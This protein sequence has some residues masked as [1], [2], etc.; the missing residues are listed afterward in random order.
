MNVGV[1]YRL[2]GRQWSHLGIC[3]T[4]R[5]H[6]QDS[7]YESHVRPHILKDCKDSGKGGRVVEGCKAPVLHRGS[8]VRKA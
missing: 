5:S 3:T 4:R 2:Q 6:S 1:L 8:M 7:A